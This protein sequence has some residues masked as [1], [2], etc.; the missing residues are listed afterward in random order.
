MFQSMNIRIKETYIF[1]AKNHFS[2]LKRQILV[3]GCKYI[4]LPNMG[5]SN[6]S[7]LRGIWLFLLINFMIRARITIQ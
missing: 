4:K 3:H 5:L 6:L 1:C 7:I 2:L